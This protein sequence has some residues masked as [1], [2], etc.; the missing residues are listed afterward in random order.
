M[1][2]DGIEAELVLRLGLE[3]GD[4]LAEGVGGGQL[5]VLP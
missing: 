2:H 3:G 4:E 5:R 1:G